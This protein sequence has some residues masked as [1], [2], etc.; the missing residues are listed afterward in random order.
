MIFKTLLFDF[1][2]WQYSQNHKDSVIVRI[3]KLNALLNTATITEKGYAELD[4]MFV[5]SCFNSI[6][7]TIAYIE[8]ANVYLEHNDKLDNW[9]RPK[10]PQRSVVAHDWLYAPENMANR[11]ISLVDTKSLLVNTVRRFMVLIGSGKDEEFVSRWFICVHVAM[12][13]FLE[14]CEGVSYG[15]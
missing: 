1:R 12:D 15:R 7:D 10:M 8:E 6:H 4:D 3:V 11:D 9:S 2:L 5:E 14:F 13:E